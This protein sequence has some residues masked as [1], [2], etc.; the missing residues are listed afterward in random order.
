MNPM[1]ET[2]FS[3]VDSSTPF[4]KRWLIRALETITGARAVEKFYLASRMQI[5]PERNWFCAA[6]Q[7]LRVNVRHDVARL[8][9]IPRTGPLIIV[10]NHPFGV[11][12]G[13]AMSWLVSCVRDDFVVLTN[14]VLL[15]APEIAPYVLPVDFDLTPQA[16]KTNVQSRAQARAHLARGGCVVIFPAGAVSTS[17]DFWGRKLAV[18]GRWQPIAAQLAE[19][20]Q[21][22]I[23]PVHFM[24]ENSR[25][26]QIVSHI[27]PMLRL[28][29]FFHELR[30]HI[31]KSI[32]VRIGAPVAYEDLP[33]FENRQAMSDYLQS[34]SA[35]L[36]AERSNPE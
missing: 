24:G 22:T 12:D 30:R 2:P 10:S 20:S 31:G 9:S 29:L 8:H 14:A 35:S 23:V 11:L 25:L 15:R 28:A 21:A 6:L 36:R 18:D 1:N 16:M 19:K 3:Y 7:T 17:P 33:K 34:L 5:T 26:F 32:D 27:H 4:A 13:I